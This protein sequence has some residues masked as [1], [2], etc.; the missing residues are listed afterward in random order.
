M[1]L[2]GCPLFC[3]A[4]CSGYWITTEAVITAAGTDYARPVENRLRGQ[5]FPG[6]MGH[7]DLLDSRAMQFSL[8]A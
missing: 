6:L 4:G 2:C 8:L 7:Q 5:G 1:L 3:W